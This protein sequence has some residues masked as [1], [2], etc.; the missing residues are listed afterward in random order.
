MRDKHLRVKQIHATGELFTSYRFDEEIGNE[1]IKF[2]GDNKD[3]LREM[4]L[5]MALK[6]ADL[7]LVS[8]DRWKVLAMNTCMKSSF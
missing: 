5:R 1:I 2:M 3:E 4:S 7:V 6:I 8:K